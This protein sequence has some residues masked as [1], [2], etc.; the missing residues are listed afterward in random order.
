MQCIPCLD[1]LNQAATDDSVTMV[2]VTGDGDY[3]SSGNDIKSFLTVSNPEKALKK[4]QDVLRLMIRAFYTFPKALICVVNGPCIGIA[5]TTAVLSDIVYAV[6]TVRIA[7]LTLNPLSYHLIVFY[8]EILAGIFPYTVRITCSMR[9][10]LFIVH[11]P[12]Y[13]GKE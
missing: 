6:D 2:A 9:R 3:Y 7:A 11:I 8:Y 5:A 10:R 1:A 4:S 12:T 13:S